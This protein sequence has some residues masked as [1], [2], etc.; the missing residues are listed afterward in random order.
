MPENAAKDL[1]R[2]RFERAEQMLRASKV[3]YFANAFTI[4]NHSDYDDFYLFSTE[5][6]I[7]LI[8]DAEQFLG[9]VRAFLAGK[10]VL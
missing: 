2:Y 8:Q 9:D 5:E 10:G 3:A 1:S 7:A 4:R 6:T